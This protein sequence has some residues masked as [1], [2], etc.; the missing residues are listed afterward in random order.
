MAVV[1]SS[2]V[3]HMR[4]GDPS[5]AGD[6]TSLSPDDDASLGDRESDGSRSTADRTD[7]RGEGRGEEGTEGDW[8]VRLG[9]PARSVVEASCSDCA[10]SRARNDSGGGCLQGEKTSSSPSC[11]SSH[12]CALPSLYSRSSMLALRSSKH[13]SND[14]SLNIS[15]GPLAS[16]KVSCTVPSLSVSILALLTTNPCVLTVRMTHASMPISAGPLMNSSP[17][18]PPPC[19]CV[20]RHTRVETRGGG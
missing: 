3:F 2:T 13:S 1:M 9:V 18:C 11:G 6:D 14:A 20:C 8:L 16:L 7:R 4:L 19:A 12:P 5:L 10:L 17:S 15:I